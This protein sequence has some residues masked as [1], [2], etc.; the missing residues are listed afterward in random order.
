MPSRQISLTVFA[1]FAVFLA[2]GLHALVSVL[3]PMF[4]PVSSLLVLALEIC[5]P[6]YVINKLN[7]ASKDFNIYAHNLEALVD[8]IIPPFKSLSPKIDKAKLRQELKFLLFLA[9]II[10]SIY[11][12]AYTSYFYIFSLSKHKQILI[13]LK[14]PEFIVTYCIAQIFTIAL[15]EELFYR[16]FLQSSLMR[17]WP[18]T[19]AIIATNAIFALAH[20]VGN[21]D[22]ARLATFFPGL[23][24]SYFVLKNK[25]IF[26]AVLFHALCNL[27]ALIL[28]E[29]I[30]VY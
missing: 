3:A 10:L 27:V 19:A 8:N 20:V 29:S 22:L 24:F 12:I 26:S 2:L 15:P 28:Y 1:V 25:S 23:V 30:I 14:F 6:F 16:A 4:S 21:G 17:L 5:L 9:F 7:L 11:I 13:S 18:T